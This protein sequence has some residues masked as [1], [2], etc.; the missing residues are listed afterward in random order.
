MSNTGTCDWTGYQVAHTSGDLLGA[1]SPVALP[2]INAGANADIAI[3]MTAPSD[4]GT[5]TGVWRNQG[6]GGTPF[7]PELTVAINVPDSP[8]DTPTPTA[9]STFTPTLMPTPTRTPTPVPTATPVPVSVEQHTRQII[10]MPN[11]TETQTID[12]PS[13]SVVVS[14]G[15]SHQTGVRV[16][17]SSQSGN[18]WRISATNTQTTQRAITITATCLSNSGGSTSSSSL[19]QPAMANDFT[20]FVVDCPSGSVVTGGGWDLGNQTNPHVYHSAKS[21]NS[22]ALTIN[23]PGGNAQ[24][25]TAYAVC[26]SGVSGT[27]AQRENRENAVPPNSTANVQQ[28]CTSGSVVTGG[29]FSMDRELTLFN[30]TKENNGW[31]NHVANPTGEEK[32]L[33]T[34]AI[35]FTP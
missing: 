18:G 10:L 2:V 15:F 9:T 23:N 8:T 16:W 11:T 3:N 25:V 30:T 31:I 35:C 24:P 22:W 27:T 34:F 17:R 12:C 13:G 33:D 21:G 5:H 28:L 1:S 14:G 6:E 29:G 19:N 4:P 20:H 7:G 26:L 32:R